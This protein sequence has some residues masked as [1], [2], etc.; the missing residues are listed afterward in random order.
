M[1][2]KVSTRARRSP[3]IRES[4]EHVWL[5]GLGA[6]A[7]AEEEGSKLFRTLVKR[8][9]G[10]EDESRKRLRRATARVEGVRTNTIGRLGTGFDGA[11]TTMLHRI[12]VPTAREIASLTRRVERLT[13]HLATGQS[14]APQTAQGRRATPARRPRVTKRATKRATTRSA[15]TS[16]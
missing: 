3:A 2:T 5:A 15:T 9:E 10:F 4:V 13:E 8:G 6:L 14:A 16:A 1:T 12:G 7:L 11:M